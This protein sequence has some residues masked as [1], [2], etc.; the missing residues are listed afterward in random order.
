MPDEPM[1]VSIEGGLEERLAVSR[2]TRYLGDARGSAGLTPVGTG[3]GAM[4]AAPAA[5]H[6]IRRPCSSTSCVMRP[7]AAQ[8]DTLQALYVSNATTSPCEAL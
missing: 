8:W 2:G 5:L 7:W 3:K 6:L 4:E 1:L